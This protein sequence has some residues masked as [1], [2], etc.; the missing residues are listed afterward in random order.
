MRNWETF[1]VK[2]RKIEKFWL[3]QN[4]VIIMDACEAYARRWAKKEDVK[5]DTLYEW[6]KSIG[7][8]LQHI[9]RRLKY[10]VNIRH[11]FIFSDADVVTELSHLHENF[12]IVSADKVS[13]NYNFVFKKYYIDILIETLWLYFFP[14]EPYIQSDR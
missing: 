4:F 14:G 6:I 10:S 7:D 5:V 1:Y 2:A 8:E 3:H 9:I 11:V 12:V 13:N